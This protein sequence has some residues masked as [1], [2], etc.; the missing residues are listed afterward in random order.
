[1]SLADWLIHCSIA[2]LTISLKGFGFMTAGKCY[3]LLPVS[4][5]PPPW[6]PASGGYVCVMGVG[7]IVCEKFGD[8][9]GV[10]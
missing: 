10:L 6:S 4:E 9:C 3:S 8:R 1:M 5:I 7:V 2:D